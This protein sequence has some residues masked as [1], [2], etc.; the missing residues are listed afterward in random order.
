MSSF[1]IRQ[2]PWKRIVT[3]SKFF[4]DF[5]CTAYASHYLYPF[6]TVNDMIQ[7]SVTEQSIVE[8]LKIN[9][10]P[11]RSTLNMNLSI[12]NYQEYCNS[13]CIFSIV[14]AHCSS[15]ICDNT[16]RLVDLESLNVNVW[17]HKKP[18]QFVESVCA[19]SL[20]KL[21]MYHVSVVTKDDMH[22]LYFRDLIYLDIYF[23]ER[24]TK[25]DLTLHVFPQ[26]LQTLLLSGT[27]YKIYPDTFPSSL[28][29]LTLTGSSLTIHDNMTRSSN[30]IDV[31]FPPH[32]VEL[33]LNRTDI[34]FGSKILPTT[35]KKLIMIWINEILELVFPETLTHLTILPNCSQNTSSTTPTYIPGLPCGLEYFFLSQN[36]RN[37]F[38]MSCLPMR[39]Q[40][41]EYW[42][43]D[44]VFKQ[45][46]IG[47][48]PT[49]LKN[50]RYS[51][52]RPII[53]IPIFPLHLQ[54]LHLKDIS[55][56]VY[57]Q[58]PKNLTDLSMSS[59]AEIIIRPQDLSPF[60]TNLNLLQGFIVT[61][62]SLPSS[63]LRLSM[64]R[65]RFSSIELDTLLPRQLQEFEYVMSAQIRTLS[66]AGQDYG[67]ST[68]RDE[69]LQDMKINNATFFPPTL[70][71]V[72]VW[73][74]SLIVQERVMH[75]ITHDFL[76]EWNSKMIDF[77]TQLTLD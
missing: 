16:L 2:K 28:T 35:L 50:L 30:I 26:K 38:L 29:S 57:L 52:V 37:G 77:F 5:L 43:N 7:L 1:L 60:L 41:F 23:V 31:Y 25:H 51:S 39:L 45:I 20:K 15:E 33:T 32:L 46:L 9:R 58:L 74:Y 76:D 66:R 34:H 71:N 55:R 40:H 27:S 19:N 62:H 59:M 14:H 48:F 72:K 18:F 73:I 65:S 64:N 21:V 67:L 6:F 3:G 68:K 75:E 36:F 13:H 11:L 24:T 12:K 69:T 63:L 42:E 61:P 54:T 49:H 56:K 70:T 44:F 10:F 53:N 17:G 47:E 8:F 22:S 4:R